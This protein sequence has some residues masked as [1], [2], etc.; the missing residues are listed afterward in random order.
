VKTCHLAT[1]VKPAKFGP[2][3]RSPSFRVEDFLGFANEM[4]CAV[5][6]SLTRKREKVKEWMGAGVVK[7]NLDVV[8][9]QAGANPT[10]VSYDAGVV[11]HYISAF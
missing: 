5:K 8:T 3:S 7:E 1:L 10:I 9:E 2:S 4:V 6:V 11:K